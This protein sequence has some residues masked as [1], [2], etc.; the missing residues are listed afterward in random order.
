[1]YNWD[2]QKFRQR[3]S[4]WWKHISNQREFMDQLAKKLRIT[5]FDD[6]AKIGA[7]RVYNNGGSYLL[8][9][10]PNLRTALQTVYPEY[11]L[12]VM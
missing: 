11:P 10:Y 3:P 9:K 12:P 8:S 1:M 2:L 5:H 7:K 6:W 4:G